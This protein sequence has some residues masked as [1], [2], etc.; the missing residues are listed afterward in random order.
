[1]RLP[2]FF[3]AGAAKSGTTSLWR[4]LLQHPDIFMPSDIIYKEPAYFSDIKGMK[5]LNEYMSLFTNAKTEKMIGEASAAYITSP[6]SPGRIRNLIPDA[7]I[8]IM[9][10][11][12][13]D[14]A[15]SLYNW[16]ACNGYEY[17]ESFEQ[18]LKFEVSDRYENES[19]KNSNPEYYYNYLYFH[20][21]LYSEQIK[22]FLD[23]FERKQLY[24]IIF[25]KFKNQVQQEVKKVFK[26]LD[27][28]ADFVPNIKTHN[29]G[30]I[31]Y[32]AHLQ[33]FIRQELS[34]Y[35]KSPY[36]N[37]HPLQNE[38]IAKLMK[39][40]THI[41]RPNSIDRKTRNLL[42]EKYAED[43]PKISNLIDEDLCNWWPDFAYHFPKKK[44]EQKMNTFEIANDEV[45]DH[46]IS[47]RYTEESNFKNK[48][49]LLEQ[50]ITI[51]DLIA[52]PNRN[53]IF[54]STDSS[55]IVF[56]GSL[57][58]II[59]NIEKNSLNH[60]R[61]APG[62]LNIEGRILR[63]ADL[64]SFYYQAKQIFKSKLYDFSSDVDDPVIFD[65]GA[66]IGLASIYFSK[67][68][69]KSRIYAY[70][71]DPKIAEMLKKNIKSFNLKN[72]QAFSKAI[73]A[74]DG[75][76]FFINSGDD[77]GYVNDSH[78]NFGIRVP[79]FRLRSFV[80]KNKIDLLKLDIEGSEFD[81]I[82]D[83]DGV[84]TNVKKIIVEVHSLNDSENSF[85]KLLRVLENNNF[86]YTLS[87]LH[88]ADW[89]GTKIETPF[90]A[91]RCDKYIIT[92]FAWQP[93]NNEQ[94]TVNTG[95]HAEIEK[96]IIELNSGENS[97]AI[98]LIKKAILETPEEKALYYA[99]AVA[100]AREDNFFEAKKLLARIPE[101]N[102]IYDKASYLLE[103]INKEIK[104]K[105]KESNLWKN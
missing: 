82:E 89:L 1:M 52:N 34:K 86:Y 103:V 25:E 69:P 88:S 101:S 10:R 8:L 54:E 19:F 12:P 20:S 32:S 56:E 22:R 17:I 48:G 70:E 71:A 29:E 63:Y 62:Q 72:V 73:W 15:Y 90:N 6:E 38:I 58:N 39:L 53:T 11:N 41:L 27:V 93:E 91:V 50:D 83:C 31:P 36:G 96:A 80:E 35:L 57:D 95:K 21:G 78:K 100:Y 76:V 23:N 30:K 85:G 75:G 77:S 37:P 3:I 14:R 59:S 49:N 45:Q 74:N 61:R 9:L 16:M 81:V 67:K 5:N 84:L 87:D 64:H 92:V 46:K 104:D 2:N 33:F 55:N 97:K 94:N 44:K 26:F 13:I 51:D 42:T 28:D 24:F 98:S 102:H 79:S 7:K 18:A 99:L 65:C 43:V 40:N 60:P 4:Y 68:Y 47:L 105:H 66:H